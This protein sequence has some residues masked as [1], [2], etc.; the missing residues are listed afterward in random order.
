MTQPLHLNCAA[1]CLNVV[2]VDEEEMMHY[3]I[4]IDWFN[5]RTVILDRLNRAHVWNNVMEG[6]DECRGGQ[7]N[8]DGCDGGSMGKFQWTVGLWED[9]L[10]GDEWID[11]S[12]MSELK[13]SRLDWLNRARRRRN[14]M[15]GVDRCGVGEL[16]DDGCGD[17]GSLDYLDG[18][19]DC[20]EWMKCIALFFN[21]MCWLDAQ[22]KVKVKVG[23]CSAE[24]SLN[25]NPWANGHFKTD[26][27]PAQRRAS[28]LVAKSESAATQR[29]FRETG[30]WIRK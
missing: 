1:A 10:F 23:R 8:D 28:D 14:V 25:S 26:T 13:M 12:R 19:L 7:L 2:A 5:K 18:V 6:G 11:C 21:R 3:L 24:W 15:E 22:M 9:W 16:D 30:A 27:S 4:I 17:G 29:C 20:Y